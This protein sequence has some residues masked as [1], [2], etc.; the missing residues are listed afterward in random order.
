MCSIK[1]HRAKQRAL[2]AALQDEAAAELTFSQQIEL[3]APEVQNRSSN[4]RH[5]LDQL[6][7]RNGPLNSPSCHSSPAMPSPGPS[8]QHQSQDADIWGPVS[9]EPA[10]SPLFNTPTPSSP[11]ENILELDEE[12]LETA[13]L[14]VLE[15]CET[16]VKPEQFRGEEDESDVED[17]VFKEELQRFLERKEENG[18]LRDLW[19]LG[20]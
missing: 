9:P 19:E 1:R 10:A 15:G 18:M 20:K 14:D 16:Q 12:D 2:E 8:D 7:E 17:D 5:S 13:L 3:L 6:L 11:Q 4:L